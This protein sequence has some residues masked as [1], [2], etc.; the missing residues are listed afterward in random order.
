MMSGIKIYATTSTL[1]AARL[2]M[3]KYFTVD[4]NFLVAIA[5]L[6]SLVEESKF[7]NNKK[8]NI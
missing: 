7:I 1:T 3:F 2:A 8:K 5:A 4:S 6:M